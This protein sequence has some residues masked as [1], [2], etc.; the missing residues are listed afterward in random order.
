M[1]KTATIGSITTTTGTFQ[2]DALPDPFDARDLPYRARLQ[3]LPA[4][5]DQRTLTGRYVMLQESNS[6]TGHA[7]AAMVNATLAKPRTKIRVSP[8]MLYYLGRRYDEFPGGEDNGSSLRGVLKGWWHHGVAPLHVWQDLRTVRD[9]DDPAFRELCA[10]YPLGAFY[11]VDPYRVDDMHSAICELHAVVASSIIHD[12]WRTPRLERHGKALMQVIRRASTDQTLGGHAYA[13]VG[14]NHIGF[15][16]QNSW[17]PNW[18]KG[19]YATLPYEEWLEAAYDAWVGRPGVPTAPLQKEQRHAIT[20]TGLTRTTGADMTRLRQHVLNIGNDGRL[21]TNGRITSSPTQLLT[22]LQALSTSHDQWGSRDIVL[23]AHGGLVDEATGLTIA[24]RQLNWWLNN[25]V[26]PIFITWQSGPGEIILDQLGDTIKRLVPFAAGFNMT[27]AVDRLIEG[28]AHRTLAWAWSELKENAI[29]ASAPAPPFGEVDDYTKAP[30]VS[31][32]LRLLQEYA[33]QHT[34][35]RLHLVGHSAGTILQGALLARAREYDLPVTSIAFLAA[36]IT[37][38]AFADLVL[39]HVAGARFTNFVLSDQR[40]LDDTCNLGSLALY[41]KSL[42]Y[43]V[44]RGFER[45]Q[46][47]EV[48]LVGMQRFANTALQNGVSLRDAI[49]NIGGATVHAPATAPDY[50]RCDA[51]THGGFDEDELTMTSVLLRIK[52]LQDS[53]LVQ[54]FQPNAPLLPITTGIPAQGARKP[55]TPLVYGPGPVA[56]AAFAIRA[57]RRRTPRNAIKNRGTRRREDGPQKQGPDPS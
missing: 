12:G 53:T 1:P 4:L 13:L 28:T 55:D 38:R 26:Y 19:G 49:A 23:F 54:H 7:V 9:L 10:A 51:R 15:L 57:E 47:H 21:S 18:G 8:Y 22:L 32:L 45:P 43:L 20:S 5:M 34:G 35:V 41:R 46:Q 48:P 24:D 42:L 17:G 3:P 40:E 16:V 11:R 14:Y 29:R 36:A 30:G 31:L 44:S 37:H 2:A 25:K 6:C 27:E 39:P 56:A 52:D 50:A 33:A